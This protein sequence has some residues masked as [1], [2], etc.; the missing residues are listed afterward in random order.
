MDYA[1]MVDALMAEDM[2][3][4]WREYDFKLIVTQIN[5]KGQCIYTNDDLPLRFYAVKTKD[6]MIAF[7][8]PHHAEIQEYGLQLLDY[9]S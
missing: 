5:R 4:V 1:K 8:I 2:V 9:V 3:E 6:K 7:F